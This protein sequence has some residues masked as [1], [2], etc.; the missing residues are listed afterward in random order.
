MSS[1]SD[2]SVARRRLLT[3][4]VLGAGALSVAAGST[5]A[6]AGI[7]SGGPRAF[8]RRRPPAPGGLGGFGGA[9]TP[10]GPSQSPTPSPAASA[11][12]SAAAQAGIAH[13]GILHTQA[14]YDRMAAKVRAGAQPWQAG[15]DR[16]VANPHAQS[17]YRPRPVATVVRGGTGQNYAV[18]FKDAAAAY[19]NALRWKVAGSREHGDTARDILNAWSGTLTAIH[20]NADRFLLAGLQGWQLAQAGEMLRGYPGFAQDKLAA[21]LRDVFYPMNNQFLTKHND[22]CITNYWANWDLCS[23]TSVLAI[24]VFCDDQA[25][26]DQAITYFKTGAGNGSILH[27]VPFLHPGG[28]AQWQE[29]G[30]DQGH[31]LMGMGQL[32]AFC[33]MAWNLGHDLFGYADNRFM[34]AAEYVAAYN[35]GQEVPFTTYRWGTG[36]NCAAREQTAVSPAGRGLNTPVWAL[37]DNHYRVRQGLRVPNIEAYARRVGPEGGGGD[38]GPNSGGY[39]CLGF[40]TLAYTL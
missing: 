19:Q 39:D 35:L 29:S 15:W 8:V 21:L 40:G 24:G 4:A 12:T 28:L 31:T 22:A 6:L 14:D 18:L 20:G 26:I 33:Q 34:R 37:L 16:L 7:R 25:K 10:P 11:T 13:P 32:G 1:Q 23:M 17:S 5:A 30:R 36:Q 38:Y 2:R 3:A 27:A 9:P